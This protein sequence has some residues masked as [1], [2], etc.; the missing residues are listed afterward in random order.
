MLVLCCGLLQEVANAHARQSVSSE[1]RYCKL[2][3]DAVHTHVQSE[4]KFIVYSV[5]IFYKAACLKFRE[6]TYR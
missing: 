4:Q 5:I 2:W 1:W 3:S 6:K